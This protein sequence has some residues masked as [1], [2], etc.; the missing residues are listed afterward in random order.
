M[1][2][3]DDMRLGQW[4]NDPVQKLEVYLATYINGGYG[5]GTFQVDWLTKRIQYLKVMALI[6]PNNLEGIQPT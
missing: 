1:S 3:I 2:I 6:D 4:D 5:P